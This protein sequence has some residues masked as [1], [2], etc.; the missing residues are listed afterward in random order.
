MAHDTAPLFAVGIDVGALQCALAI[1]RPDKSPVAKPSSFP[2]S[3]GG[4]ELLQRKLGELKAQPAS[5]WIGLE[6]TGPYWENLYHHLH[7]LGYKLLLLNP[8]QTHEFAAQRGL[9][10]KTDRIDALSIARLVLSGDARPAYV[11]EEH[12]ASYREVVRLMGALTEDAARHKMQIRDLLVVLFPEFTQV[13]KDPSGATA[14]GVLKKYPSAA[15][16]RQ[17]GVEKLA[18]LLAELAPGRYGR[19]T[20][21]ELVRLAKGSV[22][23]GVARAA[24]ERSLRMLVKQLGLLL[25][26]LKELEKELEQLGKDDAGANSLSSVGEFG[27]KTVAVLRS[28]LGDVSRFEHVDQVVAYAGMDPRVRQSGKWRGKVKLSKRGSGKLR[29]LLYMAA[30]RSIGDKDSEFGRYYRHL[31]ETGVAKKSAIM[32]VMRKML[33]VAYS[34]LKNGGVYDSSKVWAGARASS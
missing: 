8:M 22:S 3:A 32:G 34:L 19:E 24:W 31:V 18:E 17:A 20:A 26:H 30:L 23:S 14:M 5:I 6:A 28:E 13:F 25:E 7:K 1:L 2:N 27:P 9:R 10:A 12:I 29:Q 4:F 16:V 11:P 33:M 15:A 21:E